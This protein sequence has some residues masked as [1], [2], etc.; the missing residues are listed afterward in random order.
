MLA[1][2]IDGGLLALELETT[3]IDPLTADI[4]GI[5]LATAPGVA[6]YVPVGH[7]SSDDA[8]GLFGDGALAAASNSSC[9]TCSTG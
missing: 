4:I 2:A 9:R 1:A 5:A 6:C 7:T 8:G 3:S